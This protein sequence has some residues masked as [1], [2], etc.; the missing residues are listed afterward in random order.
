[1]KP[2]LCR[3]QSAG[4]LPVWAGALLFLGVIGSGC[5]TG[6]APPPDARPRSVGVAPNGLAASGA[7]PPGP[8]FLVKPYLQLGRAPRMGLTDER[9]V[10]W[11]MER[12]DPALTMEVRPRGG[13]WRNVTVQWT[14][15]DTP[16]VPPYQIGSA[17][18]MGLTPSALYEYRLSRNGRPLFA[19]TFQTRRRPGEP[20]AFAIL[21]DCGAGRR[22]QKVLAV[23]LARRRP[24]FVLVPGDIVYLTGREREYRPKFFD[25]YNADAPDPKIGAPLLRQTLFIAAV[26]NHD[27]KGRDF[28]KG[29]DGLAYYYNWNQPLNGPELALTSAYYPHIENESPAEKKAFLRATGPNYPRMGNFS[30]EAGDVHF[31]LLDSSPYVDWT[32]AKLQDWLRNDLYRTGARWKV[33]LFH[34]PPFDASVAHEGDQQMRALAPLFE[35]MKVDLVIGGHE[36]NYQRTTPLRFVP[37]RDPKTGAIRRIGQRVPGKFLIDRQYDGKAATRPD[38]VIYVTSGAG[39]QRLYGMISRRVPFYATAYA[40]R[41]SFSMVDVTPDRLIFRQIDTKGREVDRFVID[42]VPSTARQ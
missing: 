13:A 37:A 1:M 16:P 23:E 36:H 27:V 31:T 3:R 28:S 30:F 10:M 20:Y 24:A 32:D 42:Q 4:P 6:P 33:V 34:H 22:E 18:L 25:I 7:I 15:V 14:P 2:R 21:G 5:R 17:S 39:G 9:V 26:G 41:H 11:K 35:Q 12:P 40:R 8:D 19:S 38:G 29:A